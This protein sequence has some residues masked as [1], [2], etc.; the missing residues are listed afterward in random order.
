MAEL[1][2]NVDVT[3]INAAI[4]AEAAARV[5]GDAAA[6]ATAAGDATTKAN[7]AQAAAIATASADATTKAN[8]AQ[9]A[10]I[11]A[12]ATDATTKA[13]A[14]EAAAISAS[15]VAADA[16][17]LREVYQTITIIPTLLAANAVWTNMPAALTFFQ[18]STR[19]VTSTDLTGATQVRLKVFMSTTV[20][21]TGSRLR[22][23]YR[24]LADGMDVTPA[25]WISL[26]ASVNVEAS[27]TASL[28]FGDSGYINVATLAKAPILIGVFGIGGDGAIDPNF[29]GA[30]LDIKYA[31]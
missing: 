18:G 6:V 7:A 3:A 27:I 5:A 14:A 30:T 8:A 17:Y 11:S 22:V 9:A 19:W 2:V 4:T 29:I 13:N 21:A 24:T 12:A 16:R 15:A 10:A 23:M 26:G 1:T 25:K 28:A 31:L 20:G